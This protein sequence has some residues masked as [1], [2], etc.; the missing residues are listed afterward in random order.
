MV[1]RRLLVLASA[2]L[3]TGPSWAQA[4]DEKGAQEIREGLSR[5]VSVY[6]FD[7]GVLKVAPDG[8]AYRLDVDFDAFL[9]LFPLPAEVKVEIDPYM[10]RL[11]PQSGGAW[12]VEGE[13]FPDGKVEVAPQ[14][15]LEWSIDADRFSGVYDPRLAFFSSA[16]GTHGPI[17]LV[18]QDGTGRGESSYAGG[19]FSMSG[20]ASA[21][22]GVDFSSSQQ[23]TDYSDSQNFSDPDSQ[24]S[25]P[26]FVKA[27]SASLGSKGAGVKAQ[28]FLDLVAFGVANPAPELL[29]AKQDEL[30]ALLLAALPLWQELSGSYLLS[31]LSVTTP[32]GILRARSLD[33]S[34]AMDGIRDDADLDYG[35]KASGLEVASMF[36]PAWTR[37]LVPTDVDISLGATGIDLDDPARRMIAA[38]DLDRDPPVPVEVTDA[39]AATFT[40]DPPRLS[41]KPST[42]RNATSAIS[43]EGEMTFAGGEPEMRATVEAEGFDAIVTALQAA[44]SAE[45]AELLPAVMLVKGYGKSLPDGRLQWRV[46]ARADGSV[47]VNDMMVKPA[48]PNPAAL[49]QQ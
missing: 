8:D 47:F 24:V 26:V 18:T 49:D 1:A 23:M 16:S 41:L 35:F 31:D 30:K 38:L 37:P 19:S 3:V 48:D 29:K 4:V 13:F 45:V 32:M 2:L 14:Q 40:A 10:L 12:Q 27:A 34:M 17:R 39:I 36:M 33:A 7:R 11:R 9:R 43:A 22:G 46:D 28:S 21:Q 5:Y 42:I 20:T 15:S 25:F 44:G 6:A